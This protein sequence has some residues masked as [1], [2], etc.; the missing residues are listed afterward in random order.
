M[1]SEF[2]KKIEPEEPR[3]A[4]IQKRMCKFEPF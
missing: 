3:I 1:F 4:E 2:K